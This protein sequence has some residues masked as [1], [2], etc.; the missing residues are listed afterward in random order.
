MSQFFSH[1]QCNNNALEAQSVTQRQK[2]DRSIGAQAANV[3]T[4]SKER[5]E[6]RPSKDVG[7]ARK[8]RRVTAVAGR[9]WSARLEDQIRLERAAIILRDRLLLRCEIGRLE[10]PLVLLG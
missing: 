5:L 9:R 2:F 10:G 6:E 4:M 3:I 7:G 1:I 8:E